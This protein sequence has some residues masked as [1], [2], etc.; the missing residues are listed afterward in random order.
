[1]CDCCKIP[2]LE[3]IEKL[4]ER[5][6][7]HCLDK[8]PFSNGS[9]VRAVTRWHIRRALSSLML[10]MSMAKKRLLMTVGI[11]MVRRVRKE[12][13]IVTMEVI[14]GKKNNLMVVSV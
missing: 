5:G 11:S 7:V 6:H 3:L 2:G 1:M 14:F 9:Y 12:R 4:F 13:M 10:S 8:H